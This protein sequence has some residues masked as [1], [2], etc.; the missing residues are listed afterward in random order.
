MNSSPKSSSVLDIGFLLYTVLGTLIS[1]ILSGILW[2]TSLLNYFYNNGEGLAPSILGALAFALLAL[3]GA[4]A[5][6]SGV[7]I[8]MGK[9]ERRLSPP[10]PYGY[11]PIFL[12]P[13]AFIVG[14]LAF[15]KGVMTVLLAPVAQI[16]AAVAGVAFAIQIARQRGAMLTQRRFWG[17]FVTGLW[18]VPVL[19]L[20]ME[21][22]ILIPTIIAFGIGALTSESGRELLEFLSDP[23]SPS[24]TMLE[25]RFDMIV[26]EPWFIITTLTYFAI[27]VPIIEET[28]KTIVVWPWLFRR[29]S[30]SEALM[31]GIIGGS[32]YALFEAIFLSQEGASWLPI[33][34]GRTGATMMHAF[35]TGIA[36]WG[37]AEGFIH[38]RWK[39][40]IISY[41]VAIAFHG[42]WNAIAVTVAISDTVITKNESIPSI[43]KILHNGGPI[44]IILLSMVALF[45]LPWITRRFT[46]QSKESPTS[47]DDTGPILVREP[48]RM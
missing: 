13:A 29:S 16:L 45:G 28:L 5:I 32:G 43:M 37:L 22:L 1:M 44:Y 8:V 11:L 33:M 31:G 24:I 42:I 3:S 35:S 21:I 19:A 20:V 4:P 27:L 18:V 34:V 46:S 39:R 47:S 23:V 2:I 7:R 10:S 30:S 40:A 12:F 14:Y 9:E 17:Q 25:Q 26:L 38:K 6:Y 48:R 15:V 41:L 36:S